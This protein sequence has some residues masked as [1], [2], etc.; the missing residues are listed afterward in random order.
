MNKSQRIYLNTGTTSADKYVKIR[1]EQDVDILEFMSISISTKDIYQSFNADYGV[2]VGRVI[3]NDGIGVPN[4]KISIFIPLTDSDALDGNIES[5]YPYKSPRDVNKEGKRYNLLPRV[6]KINSITKLSSPPQAFGSFP[7]KEEMVTN[8]PFLDVYKKYY[9]YTALTN[10]SG[11]YMIFGAPIG[12]QLV[13][14]SVDITDIGEYSMTP[15]SMVTNLGY[16]PNLFEKDNT[17]IK[18]NNNLDILPNIETQEISVEIIPFWGDSENF[19]IGITRQDFKIRSLLKNTF[20]IFGSVF[21]DG[22][23]SM[24]GEN[25]DGGFLIK[26]FYHIKGGNHDEFYTNLGVRSKRVGKITE[27]V[28]CYPTNISDTNILTNDYTSEMV[29]LQPEDYSFYK[30]NGDFVFII[31]CNR[32]KVVTDELGRQVAVGD[33]YGGGVFTQFKGFI[34][35]EITPEDIP[36]NMISHIGSGSNQ[37]AVEPFRY[38]IKIPQGSNTSPILGETF[39]PDNVDPINTKKWRGQHTTFTGGTIYSIARHHGVVFNNEAGTW[40]TG[41]PGN[42]GF[43]KTD[44]INPQNVSSL[45]PVWATGIIYTNSSD[46]PSNQSYDSNPL[47]GSEWLNFSLYLPQVG[48]LME[49]TT[50]TNNMLST[51]NYTPK[52]DWNQ[53]YYSNQQEIAAKV[54]NTQ[55]YARADIH[56]TDFIVVPKDDLILFKNQSNKGFTSHDIT[57][58]GGTLQGNYRKNWATY[59]YFSKGVGDSNCINYLF[60]LGIV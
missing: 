26:E 30:N 36:M 11:D 35:I 3:A 52:Y 33:D 45:D 18:P 24:W 2:L 58:S 51:T 59:P 41:F 34:T 7:I 43:L 27:R 29:V 56:M 57:L 42:Y 40:D 50:E 47:F 19:D 46:V 25:Y 13:H 32:N 31:S 5:I 38:K 9:K 10:N 48:R 53:V 15:A 12:T 23:N 28:Y 37:G 17:K 55:W 44:K 60:E 14:M 21:T 16:S 6:S 20:I 4:A 49:N 39:Y 22:V 1:L 8:Q 54:V